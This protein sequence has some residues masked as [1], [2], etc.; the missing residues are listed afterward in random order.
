MTLECLNK[1]ILKA[2]EIKD[3]SSLGHLYLTTGK[4][5]VDKGDIDHGCFLLTAAYVF[6]L[7]AGLSEAE[8]ARAIL[9]NHGR[10]E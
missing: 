3:V 5:I 7:E 8:D 9:R 10:E 6:C 1:K 2:H 4:L